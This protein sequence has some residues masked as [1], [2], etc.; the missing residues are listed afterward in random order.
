MK[1]LVLAVFATALLVLTLLSPWNHRVAKAD[2]KAGQPSLSVYMGH[3]QRL[4]H[5][6]GLSVDAQNGDLA[7]F[8]VNEI[9]ETV[10]YISAQYP[11]Y[12]NV[13]VGALITAMLTPYITPLEKA[14]KAKDWK[15]AD[16]AYNTLLTSGCNGCHTATQHGF[17][18]IQRSKTNAFA[19]QF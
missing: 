18:K 12:D 3:M 16:T 1:K 19:Q 14:V 7:A 4:A 10:G 11:T 17:I 8:Y 6:L 2:P 9:N 5:K 13:Q 15:T